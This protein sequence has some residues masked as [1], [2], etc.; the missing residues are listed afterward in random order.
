MTP[1]I[2]ILKTCR[3][4]FQAHE[5]EHDGSADSYGMEAAEK[6]GIDPDRIFK[7]LVVET[8]NKVMVV[9]IVPVSH[10]LDTK[11][12]AKAFGAKK[13]KMADGKMVEKVTGYV[14]GGVSPIGQKKKL[15][16]IIDDMAKNFETI[17][18]SAGRRGL[19]IELTTEDLRRLTNATLATIRK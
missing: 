18:V 13:V 1:A 2:K 17:F 15:A 16:T 12:M 3:I 19:Q 4:Q 11:A 10:Q 6:L 5:Y 14:L 7:T 8:E 9:G